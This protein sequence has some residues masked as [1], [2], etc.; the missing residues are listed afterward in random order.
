MIFIFFIRSFLEKCQNPPKYPKIGLKVDIK[1]LLDNDGI[2]LQ[3]QSHREFSGPCPWCGGRDRFRVWPDKG[4]GSFWCR[5]CG[6]GGDMVRYHMLTTGKRYFDACLGL[7]IEPRFKPQN[8]RTDTPER[9]LPPPI[10]WRRAAGEFIQQSQRTLLSNDGA[11]MRV[12][13]NARGINYD[14]IEAASLGLNQ[15]DRYFDRKSWGI[16]EEKNPE[17]GKLKKVWIPAGLVIPCFSDGGPIRIRIRRENPANG[18][19]VTVSGSVKRPMILGTLNRV[20]VVESDLDAILVSQESGDLVSV[21]SLGS[22]S[23]RPDAETHTYLK[24]ASII[25]L[26]LDYDQAGASQM[27]WWAD[28]YGAKVKRWPVSAGKDPGEA[29]QSEVNIRQWI[30]AGLKG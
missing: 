2:K 10:Q 12:Y 30:E 15:V 1:T 25:L 19:Y 3:K 9:I 11:I 29:Y 13:L 20:I 7:G 6:K 14:S 22:V 18:R 8:R 16:G 4:G 26:A 5:Q 27:K 24:D 17:T 21:I 28:H 23:H